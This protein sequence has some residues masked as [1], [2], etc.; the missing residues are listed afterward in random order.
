MKRRYF[1][2]KALAE[3]APKTA[4]GFVHQALTGLLDFTKEI[5]GRVK[6]LEE[7]LAA[8]PAPSPEP[9]VL[10]ES[11]DYQTCSD[12]LHRRGQY[13]ARNRGVVS[14]YATLLCAE[15]GRAVKKVVAPYAVNGTPLINTYP[16]EIL[17]EV[18][19]RLPQEKTEQPRQTPSM[20]PRPLHDQENFRRCGVDRERV[21]KGDRYAIRR[22]AQ[23]I[24]KRDGFPVHYIPWKGI[25]LVELCEEPFRRAFNQIT[26]G[27]YG[28]KENV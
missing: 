22:L 13:S 26:G 19:V 3:E 28:K 18:V 5:D 7:R 6:I 12:F 17:N 2:V 9:V 10:D 11:G 14:H 8:S 23:D 1:L 4:M 15:R 27:L 20:K 16:I 24:S 25:T 21:S